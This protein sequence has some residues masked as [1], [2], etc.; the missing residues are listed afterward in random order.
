MY[1]YREDSVRKEEG[2]RASK[3]PGGLCYTKGKW[4]EGTWAVCRQG[5]RHA[6]P[7]PIPDS[8]TMLKKKGKGKNELRDQASGS[9]G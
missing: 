6:D 9:V 3:H 8:D 7:V 4:S 1:T 5:G 2:D